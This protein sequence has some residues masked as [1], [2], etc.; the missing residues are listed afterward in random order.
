MKYNVL[1]FLV[2]AFCTITCL[3]MPFSNVAYGEASKQSVVVVKAP[4]QQDT[5]AVVAVKEGE[6]AMDKERVYWNGEIIRGA[7]PNSFI[8]LGNT[9]SY[10]KDKNKVYYKGEILKAANARDFIIP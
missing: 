10:A 2:I 8:I 7:D 9:G 1:Q 6:Y 5:G 3:G 4:R